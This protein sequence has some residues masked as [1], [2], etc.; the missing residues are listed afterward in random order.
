M[1]QKNSMEQ[2]QEKRIL[3]GVNDAHRNVIK[4]F[5]VYAREK[6][7]KKILK[8][9]YVSSCSYSTIELRNGYSSYKINRAGTTTPV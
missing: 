9:Y 3:S 5:P 7:L 8:G 4:D 6:I 1:L 2:E